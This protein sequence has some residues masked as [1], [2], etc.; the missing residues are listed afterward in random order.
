VAFGSSLEGDLA[1]RDFTVNAMAI[2][3]PTLEFVDRHDGLADLANR[4]L[5]T[6]STPEE[7]FADDPLRMMRAARFT[8]QLGFSVVPQVRAAMAE[9]A[10]TLSMVSAERVREELTKLLLSPAPRTGLT[11]L[12]D[13]GLTAVFLPELP[14]LRLEV[15]EHHRHKDVYEHSL[16]VLEQ[17]MAL[18]GP[19]DGPPESVP[20]PDLVLRLAALLHDVGKPATRR[21]EPGGGVSFH[22]HE[23]VG[24]KMVARRLREMRYDKD[25]VKAVARLVELHLRFHGYGDGR[26]TD[27]A[28]RRYVTDAGP[29]L[30]RLHRLTRSDCTTRN[31]RRARQLAGTYDE[32]ERRITT[33][34]S[35]EELASVRPE[36]NGHE[37]AEAL[38]IAPG[39]LLGRAYQHLLAVR[40]EEGVIGPDA[41][42]Q[43]LLAWWAG[44]PES[45]AA[46]TAAGI[47][48]GMAAGAAADERKVDQAPG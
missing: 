25:T 43:R 10:G 30:E 45:I 23:V 14:A 16:T 44:Q 8:A 37:I 35:E 17:A 28:V 41:A 31:A 36:L 39:P 46:G 1:R 21:F 34:Q 13:T 18:E 27:S 19:A 11:L 12:V 33:L 2:R 26:W 7:S 15:D 20:G 38:G 5:R 29:L 3:L 47:V 9:R 48:A 22:H 42:R 24:A 4:R 32:L 40:M 6:P